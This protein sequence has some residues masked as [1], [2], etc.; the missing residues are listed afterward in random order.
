MG[1]KLGEVTFLIIFY[2]IAI[3]WLHPPNAFQFNF[4]LRDSASQESNG[5]NYCAQADCPR[6][7][8]WE[9][10]P[11]PW[12]WREEEV[13]GFWGWTYMYADSQITLCHIS[14]WQSDKRKKS[15]STCSEILKKIRLVLSRLY[16]MRP[17]KNNICATATVYLS[18]YLLLFNIIVA[19]K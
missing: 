13:T 3:S 15:H 17:F 12:G 18:D 9:N 7:L 19:I 2:N 4:L 6:L 14:F 16:C 10:C 1:L 5:I 8:I 11:S